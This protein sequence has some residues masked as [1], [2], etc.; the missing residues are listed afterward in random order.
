[1]LGAAG[2]ATALTSG[3]AQAAAKPGYVYVLANGKT[4]SVV[5]LKRSANG[6]LTKIATTR[7]GRGSNEYLHVSNALQISPDHQWLAAVVAGG[8]RIAL[9]RIGGN[10][11]PGKVSVAPS[12]GV[13]PI[14]VA[15]DADRLYVLNQGVK[16][17]GGN[18]AGFR[19]NAA[20]TI[21]GLPGT[22][23]ALSSAKSDSAQVG[24]SPDR[25]TL[26]VTERFNRRLSSWP[27]KVATGA[28][29][30]R[31]TIKA[32]A[33]WPFGFGFSP[34]APKVAL[35]TDAGA[36]AAKGKSLISSYT[37]L[38]GKLKA[39]DTPLRTKQTAACWIVASQQGYAYIVNAHG[40]IS[41]YKVDATGRLFGQRVVKDRKTA[42]DVVLSADETQLYLTNVAAHQVR[43]YRITASGG[44]VFQRATTLNAVSLSGIAAS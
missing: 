34:V 10:G 7:L 20:G 22:V 38:G 6:R 35:I 3:V 17:L 33:S 8:N 44:L 2:L 14:S 43:S 37:V 25:S 15:F 19:F 5:T 23:R 39:V 12:G 42:S 29:G 4:A 40:T 26:I 27:I 9:A 36:G 21:S 30:A 16:K 32:N 31:T 28:L 13:H 1:V 18:V 11:I 24:V 41:I